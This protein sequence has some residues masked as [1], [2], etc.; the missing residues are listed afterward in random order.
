MRS[1]GGGVACYKGDRPKSGSCVRCRV[2]NAIRHRP[3]NRGPKAQ[4]RNA[5]YY[6]TALGLLARARSSAKRRQ[7]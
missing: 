7:A 2:V 3:V 5:R 4:A 1:H 6:R